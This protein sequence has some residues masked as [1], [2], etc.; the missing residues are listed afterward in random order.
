MHRHV[1]TVNQN[2]LQWITHTH[3]IDST[4]NRNIIHTHTHSLVLETIREGKVLLLSWGSDWGQA[5]LGCAVHIEYDR[6]LNI[7][8]HRKPTQKTIFALWFSSPIAP[9]AGG[10]QSPTLPGSERADNSAGKRN[11]QK[12]IK[13]VLKM[14]GYSKQVSMKITKRYTLD[15]EATRKGS[16]LSFLTLQGN[17]WKN[18]QEDL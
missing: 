1:H 12:H 4:I 5:F 6:S 10:Y 15:R 13:E 9:Q 7:K 17:I 18:D 11:E 2:Q 16:T 8:V 3:I 14:C